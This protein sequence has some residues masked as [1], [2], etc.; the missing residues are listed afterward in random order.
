[1]NRID[2]KFKELAAAGRKALVAFL[3]AGDPDYDTSL[4]ILS[5]ACAAGVD[6]VELG[7]PFSDPTADGPTIQ[8]ASQRALK[9]GMSLA[10]V[11][12]LAAALRQ[13]VAT[14]IILFSYYNPLF[15]FGLERF[16]AAAAAAGVDGTLVVDLPPEEAAPLAAALAPHRLH[17]IR[18]VA[19]TTTPQRLQMLCAGAGG[20][21]Y[22]IS[23]TGVTG[24]GGVDYHAIARHAATVKAASPH[25]VCIGFG[26]TSGNDAR[27]L[28]PMADG[29]VVG[30]ALVEIIARH[31]TAPDLPQRVAAL[32]S[33]LRSGCDDTATP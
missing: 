7:V 27:A 12:E 22:L 5:A 1:M 17:I 25:P 15:K 32:L 24:S 16:A 14:P 9:S 20:F 13:R 30:S 18:L 2:L 8:R 23:R 31:T 3:T 10:R 4:Q 6:I 19:P 26:I 33:E 29:V 21:I 28:A 11:L